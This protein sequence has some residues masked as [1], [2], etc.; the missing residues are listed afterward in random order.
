M[1]FRDRT[2]L[3]TGA[4]RGIGAALAKAFAAE[5]GLVIVNYRRNAAAALQVVE[6]CEAARRAGALAI[7]ADVTS[8]AEVEAMLARI[9]DE[10]GKARRRRQ[11]RL[12]AL[13]LRPR[14]PDPLLGHALVGLSAQIRWRAEGDL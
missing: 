1:K 12:R 10:V 9:A 2:I 6:A 3:V 14:Q 8:E 7:A 5:G 4:S 11:Q 13:C